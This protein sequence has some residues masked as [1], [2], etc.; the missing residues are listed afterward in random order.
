[1]N[2][3]AILGNKSLWVGLPVLLGSGS[4]LMVVSDT[5]LGCV[6]PQRRSHGSTT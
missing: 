5:C 3:R 6:P 4:I 1:M 2:L